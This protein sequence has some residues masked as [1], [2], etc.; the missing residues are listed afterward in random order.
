MDLKLEVVMLPAA[1]VHRAKSFYEAP[2][3]PVGC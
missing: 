2:W 1:D 3:L